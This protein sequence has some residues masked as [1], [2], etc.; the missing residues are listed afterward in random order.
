MSITVDPLAML[1]A[2]QALRHGEIISG[3]STLT[4]QVARLLGGGTGSWQASR[5]IRVALAL[6]G[7]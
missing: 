6:E 4:M 1:R 2:T 5:Q 7:G 3:G